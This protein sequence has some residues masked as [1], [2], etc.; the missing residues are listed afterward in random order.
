VTVTPDFGQETS[1][2]KYENY[3]VRKKVNK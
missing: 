1:H 2:R 3:D